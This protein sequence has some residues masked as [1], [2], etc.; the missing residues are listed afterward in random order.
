MKLENFPPVYYISLEESQDR[1]EKLEHQFIE[2]G[3][4][5]FKSLISKRFNE[6]DDIVTGPLS[7]KMKS[8]TKGAVISHLKNI[9]RWIEETDDEYAIFF[10]DDVSFETVDYWNFSWNDFINELPG[11]WEAI[12][13]MWIRFGI[14]VIEFRER[15]PDDWSAA[16]FMITRDYGKKLIDK[17]VI[18]SNEFNFDLGSKV[19]VVE[20][21]L[22]SLG[23]VYT[24]PLFVEDVSI[25]ST[26]VQ[27][28][29]FED[30]LIKD[31]Q[32]EF[33]HESYERISSWWKS[34]AKRKSLKKLINSQN[35]FPNSFDWGG[36]NP[37]LISTFKLEFE[38]KK[39][40]ERYYKIKPNDIVVDIGA[41]VGSFTYSILN[42]NPKS[43]YCVE[44][45]RE[46]FGS[47]VRNTSKFT[48]KT[49]IVYVNK[50]ISDNR[51]DVKIFSGNQNV[52]GGNNNFETIKFK[53][54]I[55]EYGIKKIDFL[56]LD[57][58][59]G[60]YDI[61]NEENIDWI[62]QNVSN[63]A[64]E[65]HLTYPGC[66][67]KFFYFRDNILELFDDY[68]ILTNGNQNISRGYELNVTDWI[69]DKHFFNQFWGELMIYTRS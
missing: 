37:E 9:K 49:P 36:F 55:D 21:I 35:I 14:G 56:K 26:F 28:P 6:C 65:F 5:N 42:K 40:Y 32:G 48:T 43:V 8:T 7:D 45:S 16:A 13:L 2:N 47:L 12:Q 23:K 10:E 67:D 52:Y 1:R 54:F 64:G 57:C 46:L 11:D 29:E 30:N 22:Y 20:S 62:L 4:T 31:G 44:P 17:Y 3:I 24:F 66:K 18:N 39:I 33:H 63:I 59:G 25:P 60:E 41:S 19:P 68:L 34:V 15:F 27:S 51:E 69:F 58:E 61:F 38:K 53:E 50:A